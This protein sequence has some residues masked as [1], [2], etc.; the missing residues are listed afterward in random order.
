VHH[1]LYRG[2]E[3]VLFPPDVGASTGA[4]SA[5]SEPPL[6]LEGANQAVPHFYKLEFP[7]YDGLDDP[8]N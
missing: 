5:S 4:A 7:T 3:G 6:R 1:I 8:L 2:V